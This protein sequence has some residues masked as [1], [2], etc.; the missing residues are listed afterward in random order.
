MVG[1][2]D[3]RRCLG[4]YLVAGSTRVVGCLGDTCDVVGSTDVHRCFG[5]D[6]TAGSTEEDDGTGNSRECWVRGRYIS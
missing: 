1:S 5:D 3:V 4:D 6:T 2:T